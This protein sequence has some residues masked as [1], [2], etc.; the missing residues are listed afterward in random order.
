MQSWASL[1][2]VQGRDHMRFPLPRRLPLS[3]RRIPTRRSHP[4]GRP[5]F[6]TRLTSSRSTPESI[7]VA[8]GYFPPWASNFPEPPPY[9]CPRLTDLD[10]LGSPYQRHRRVRASHNNERDVKAVVLEKE[11]TSTKYQ[12]SSSSS[13]VVSRVYRV[14]AQEN[15]S[16]S[17]NVGGSGTDATRA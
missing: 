16:P 1:F 8:S 17:L 2:N 4:L 14:C 7:H 13:S 3:Q 10:V 6:S 11:F 5:L 12:Q 15:V 9:P